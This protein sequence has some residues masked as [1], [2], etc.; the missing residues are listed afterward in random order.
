MYAIELAPH[1]KDILK[2]IQENRKNIINALASA[3][4]KGIDSKELSK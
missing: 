1:D 3:I 4:Q 2:I